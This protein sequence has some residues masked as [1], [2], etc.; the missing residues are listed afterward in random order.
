MTVRRLKMRITSMQHLI[1]YL[2]ERSLIS[3]FSESIINHKGMDTYYTF[4]LKS[5]VV[6]CKVKW[7]K[8]GSQTPLKLN[9]NF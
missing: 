3:E 6:K 2:K 8:R 9:A 7:V 5:M 1:D 4:R